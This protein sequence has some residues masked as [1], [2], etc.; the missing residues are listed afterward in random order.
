[1]ERA[2]NKRIEIREIE[3]FFDG[4]AHFLFDFGF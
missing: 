3:D 4:F 2:G 1:M